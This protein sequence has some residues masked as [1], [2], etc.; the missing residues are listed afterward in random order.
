MDKNKESHVRS[1]IEVIRIL[2]EIHGGF[3]M[4]EF[5]VSY[6]RK[7]FAF[8]DDSQQVLK[9]LD[10]EDTAGELIQSP[11][12]QITVDENIKYH[13]IDRFGNFLNIA[14]YYEND[15]ALVGAYP[16]NALALEFKD[17]VR[18]QADS[19]TRVHQMLLDTFV[20]MAQ[21]KANIFHGFK[22][23]NGKAANYRNIVTFKDRFQH[24]NWEDSF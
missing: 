9:E 2:G 13:R 22:A 20:T 7:A 12:F 19:R 24:S 4:P 10:P 16:E 18:T 3:I 17:P 21:E 23:N 8:T 14:S 5:A 11:T 6:Q 15:A 1:I